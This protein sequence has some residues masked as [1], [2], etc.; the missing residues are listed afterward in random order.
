VEKLKRLAV[1]LSWL[2]LNSSKVEATSS[3]SDVAVAVS[4]FHL[5]PMN[6]IVDMQ[7]DECLD[8]VDHQKLGELKR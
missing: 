2:L 5:F 1:L 8:R 3:E 7:C 4:D 6:G